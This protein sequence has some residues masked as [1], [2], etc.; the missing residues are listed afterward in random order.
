M[1]AS[2]I[3]SNMMRMPLNSSPTNQPLHGPVAPKAMLQVADP[4]MPILCSMP[5]TFASLRSRIASSA[6]KL[7][8]GTMNSERPFVPAGAPGV[9]ASTKWITL[10]VRSWSPPEMKIFSPSSR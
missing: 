6:S 7:Y 9:R 3:I 5:T 1:R 4:L 2:F 8:F 10:F